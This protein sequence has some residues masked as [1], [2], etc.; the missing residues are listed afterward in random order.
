MNCS[1]VNLILSLFILLL[2]SSPILSFSRRSSTFDLKSSKYIC[3]GGKD[4]RKMSK[5][6]ILQA[7][8]ESA[9]SPM[10]L[11]SGIEGTR[12]QVVIDCPTLQEFQPDL[13]KVCGWSSCSAEDK[14][15]DPKSVPDKEY[16]IWVP[17][18]ISP[19]TIFTPGE[20]SKTCFAGFMRAVYKIDDVK[21]SIV[22]QD[23]PG[24]KILP[25][26]LSPETRAQSEYNCGA[27]SI[28]NIIPDIPDPQDEKYFSKILDMLFDMGYVSGLTLQA[29]PYDFRRD[30]RNDP[31]YTSFGNVLKKLNYM[32]NK[33]AVIIAHSMGNMRMVEILW[34]MPQADKDA[35]IKMYINVSGPLVGAVQALQD[36][37]CGDESTHFA[38][39]IGIDFPTFQTAVSNLTSMFSLMPLGTFGKSANE[40]WMA[41]IQARI[42]YEDLSS[43]SEVYPWLPKRDQ[44]CFTE[45]DQKQCRSGV[46]NFDNF[47][48]ILGEEIT[49]ESLPN[50]VDK[51]GYSDLGLSGFYAIDPKYYELPNPGVP[52]T[53]IYSTQVDT[54]GAYTFDK[55]PRS[56]TANND[57]CERNIDFKISSVGGDGTVNSAS[58]I[59]PYLKWADE[60][61]NKVANA[62]PVK[63][64]Q[65]CSALNQRLTPY[66]S[67]SP[68]GEKIVNKNEYQGLECNCS[69]KRVRDCSHI[70]ILWLDSMNEFL[71]N[72]LQSGESHPLNPEVEKMTESEL[73]DF[74]SQCSMLW[75]S[76][77]GDQ[78]KT[79]TE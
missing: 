20:D 34:N 65:V 14:E 42:K 67:T 7:F 5:K 76:Y 13:F 50:L 61:D 53:L 51:Y 32:T 29:I 72:T 74:V 55:D 60:F 57:F 40:P 9:C 21:K 3:S 77:Y 10:M 35:L 17:H 22:Y 24:V 2:A 62:K 75:D 58:L 79:Q 66:D 70:A 4:P 73:S 27:D 64:V 54:D 68:S 26:G 63:V 44:I 15:R 56:K 41:K 37:L 39:N 31:M 43:D 12:L 1:P 25:A 78:K 28:Q 33:K 30:T 23:A 11:V 45:Y 69:Q 38:F 18:P 16:L 46:Y 48:S 71:S 6:D 8:A 19:M 47:G 36:M 59:T 49:G 52:M